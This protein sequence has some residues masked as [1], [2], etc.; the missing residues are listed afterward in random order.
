MTEAVPGRER[1][2]IERFL[3]LMLPAVVTAGRYARQ[4]QPKISV[5]PQKNGDSWTSVLTDADLGVQHYFEAL[6]IAHCPDWFFYGEE[7]DQSFN[8]DYFDASPICVWLDPIN[9]TRLYR[10]GADTFD[11]LV[12]LTL[13]GKLLATLSAMP[14]RQT[15]YGADLIHGAYRLNSER[16]DH[17]MPVS[18]QSRNQTLAVYQADRWRPYLPDDIEIFD[19]SADYRADDVRC[20]MNSVLTGELG[21]YL[22]GDVA[23]LDV[24]ATAFNVTQAGGVCSRPDGTTTDWFDAFSGLR[25]DDLLVCGNP[26]LHAA[27]TAALSGT[28]QR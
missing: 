2:L 13:N 24:G 7:R 3:D 28:I 6:L 19:V 4:L 26:V 15:I 1:D 17:R 22:F 27:V 23:L 10:D 14:G 21:G 12:S 20:C 16:L 9:G 8:T 5:R 25:R 11:V 18:A